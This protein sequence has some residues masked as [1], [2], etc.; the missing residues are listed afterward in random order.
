[1]KILIAE[2]DLTSRITLKT[3]LHK[4]G[5]EILVAEDGNQAWQILQ[6]DNPKLAIFDRM[7]PGIE[8]TELC[9]RIR[10]KANGNY[11]YI[12]LLTAKV[13]NEDIV[14]GLDAGADVG[15]AQ[16]RIDQPRDRAFFGAR[17]LRRAP[18][19]RL[20]MRHQLLAGVPGA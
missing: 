6:A 14:T 9:R 10:K 8:G 18:G 5:H 20:E 3:I 13:E 1:M 19:Q 17:G 15:H 11:I 12:I 7:M 2:D 4:W 16:T